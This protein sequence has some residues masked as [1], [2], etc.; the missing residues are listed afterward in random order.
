MPATALLL[1][2]L[3]AVLHASW[4]IAA[5]QAGGDQRFTLLTSLMTSLLWLPA[6]LARRSAQVPNAKVRSRETAKIRST[7]Q[8][9]WGQSDRPCG[10]LRFP[11]T[12]SRRLALMGEGHFQFCKRRL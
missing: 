4:N 12:W 3:A 9:L 5:K 11:T 10:T 8:C 7:V 1:V 6:G 2:L